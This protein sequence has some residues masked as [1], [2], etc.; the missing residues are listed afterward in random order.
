MEEGSTLSTSTAPAEDGTYVGCCHYQR[1][2]K[3]VV[4]SRKLLLEALSWHCN[5][6]KYTWVSLI[7]IECDWI[8]TDIIKKCSLVLSV[9]YP[10]QRSEYHVDVIIWTSVCFW[11]TQIKDTPIILMLIKL[12]TILVWLTPENQDYIVVSNFRCWAHPQ[13]P[14]FWWNW[15]QH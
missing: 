13:S 3:F 10:W 12:F 1:R 15:H 2:S 8:A 14:S 7:L 4:G 5:V 6:V 9:Y 11:G